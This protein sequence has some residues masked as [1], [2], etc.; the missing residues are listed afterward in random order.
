M[1]HIYIFS[2]QQNNFYQVL[3]FILKY[4]IK[5]LRNRIDEG[6]PTG[7]PGPDPGPPAIFVWPPPPRY[8]K[9][10]IFVYQIC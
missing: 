7:G 2:M 8:S 3:T 1:K 10:Q 6:C 4:L 5:D 9:L